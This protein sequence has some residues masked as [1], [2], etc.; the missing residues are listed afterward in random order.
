MSSKEANS[1]SEPIS[2]GSIS[3]RSANSWRSPIGPEAFRAATH[4]ATFA[5]LETSWC[6]HLARAQR[7]MEFHDPEVY[8]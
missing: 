8:K 2:V 6:H 7:F 5:D 3:I 1:E 4:C